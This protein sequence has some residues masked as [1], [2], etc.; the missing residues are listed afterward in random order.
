MYVIGYQKIGLCYVVAADNCDVASATRRQ[1]RS[2][3]QTRKWKLQPHVSACHFQTCTNAFLHVKHSGQY[4]WNSRCVRREL[5]VKLHIIAYLQKFSGQ[6]LFHSK[7]LARAI[8]KYKR[9]GVLI[10]RSCR[11]LPD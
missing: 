6:S 8:Y 9:R 4:E 10:I 2:S 3:W 5:M 11:L 7:H 1:P